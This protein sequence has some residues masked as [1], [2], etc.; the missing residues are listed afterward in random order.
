MRLVFVVL[1][2]FV[3]VTGFSAYEFYNDLVVL[4]Y[5][6]VG[7]FLPLVIYGSLIFFV[8]AINPLLRRFWAPLALRGRE[9]ALVVAIILT[10]AFVPSNG[11]GNHFT[12]LLMMPHHWQ[13]VRMDWQEQ[14]PLS[15]LPKVMLADPTKNSDEALDGF[16]QSLGKNSGHI[17]LRSDIPWYAW[18]RTLSWWIP[19]LLS[20]IA[21]LT[22]VGLVVHRQWAHHEQIP[23]PIAQFVHAILPDE[24]GRRATIFSNRWFQ[25]GLAAVFL[26]H[27]N[28][29]FAMLFPRQMIPIPRVLD[30]MIL[31]DIFKTLHDGGG[32]FALAPVVYIT[33]VCFAYLISAEVAIS[34]GLAPIFYALFVGTMLKYGVDFAGWHPFKASLSAFIAFGACTGFFLAMLYTGRRH[35]INVLKQGLF[36]KGSEIAQTHEKWGMRAAL[37]GAVSFVILMTSVGLN[38]Q[39]A[40][41]Y[42]ILGSI[43]FIVLG[44]IVAET[45]VFLLGTPYMPGVILLG[46]LGERA[47]GPVNLLILFVFGS[48]LMIAARETF[49]P[50]FI[51]AL[52]LVDLRG[53]NNENPPPARLGRMAALGFGAIIVSM[54]VAFPAAIYWSYD[55]G[56][57]AIAGGWNHTV[58]PT[59]GIETAAGVMGRLR[60]QGIFAESIALTGWQRLFALTPHRPELICFG[61]T[62]SL[63]LLLSA[64]RFRFPKLPLHP[65]FFIVM[66]NSLANNIAMSVLIGGIFKA[67]VLRFGGVV[68]YQQ[69]KPF[70]M[71]LIAG[72]MLAGLV[73]SLFSGIYFWS[74]GVALPCYQLGG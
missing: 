13:R 15:Y 11:L 29:Y 55:Q 69:T 42:T 1:L 38:W 73:A 61:V 2:A 36:L 24:N 30:F 59:W 9:L 48:T 21:I 67:L 10:M 53:P 58:L 47:M 64:A 63:V 46:V 37:M 41:L 50:F 25:I 31:K 28:N 54:F 26:F 33:A 5:S 17:S 39:I 35:Y 18:T 4:Q 32:D 43:M 60:A 65:I 52:R 44:R 74:T 23:Y 22:G 34:V 57:K 14:Q 19:T 45:G 49:F 27:M 51:H 20:F 72:E 56:A 16:V 40:I 7:S 71:G 12:F 62:L 70:V 66:C 6:L 3:I 8:L 68:V